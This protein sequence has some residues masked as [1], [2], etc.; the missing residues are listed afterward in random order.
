MGAGGRPEPYPEPGE[1]RRTEIVIEVQ[2]RPGAL[3]AV[4]EVLGDAGVNIVAAAVF[5]AGGRGLIHLVVDDQDA[6]LAAL[7]RAEVNVT[8]IR[9]VLVVTLEDR[10]GQLGQFARKL[11]VSGI[12]IS[13]LYL[14]GQN[15]G[16]KELIVA[17]DQDGRTRGVL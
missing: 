1:I 7:K 2:D 3:A 8:A 12:N 9:D 10:P 4:G 16:D 6:A 17:L 5:V 11:A 13:G 14:A 15:G